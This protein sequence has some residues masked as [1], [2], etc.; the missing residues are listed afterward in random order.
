MGEFFNSFR[1][2]SN[3]PESL[4]ARTMVKESGD[5]LAKNFQH[6]TQQLGEIQAD[7]DFRI[8][9]KVEEINQIT[10]EI[11]QLNMKV[12]Q[13]E[14][15]G[16]PANDERDRRD[17]LVK[18]L[19][20]KVNVRYAEGKSGELTIT[21]G[22]TAVLVS[23]TSSTQ[24][25]CAATGPRADKKEGNFDIF[26]KATPDSSP[27]NITKQLTGGE[28]GGLLNVRD[29]I[30]NRS[31]D[32]LDQL[33]FTLATEVN[34][35]HTDGFD[36]YNAQGVVFFNQPENVKGA[37][38]NISVNKAIREDVNKI[39]AAAE[40]DA[41]GDNRIANILSALEYKQTLGDGTATYDDY[42]SG[43]VGQIGIETQRSNTALESQKDIVAQ[44]KNIRESVSGVSLDEETTKMIEFQKSFRC[45]GA[46]DSHRRRNDGH[47]LNLKKVVS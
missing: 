7:A 8:A 10:K 32:Q 17:Q 19:G 40:P 43:L 9:A 3:N 15:T 12:A 26:F 28:M 34:K 4:A 42:Y 14:V 1:E 20:Q 2:L 39:A 37:A 35:A 18:E 6:V 38:Q 11:A 16:V 21:A 36:R 25:F 45:V 33:A 13:V 24:L 31:L 30:V 29:D 22:N 23:G 41:P 44:L 47:G 27:F 46:L 5:F